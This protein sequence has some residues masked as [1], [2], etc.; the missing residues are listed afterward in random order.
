MIVNVGG[1][2]IGEGHPC[3]VILELG[4]NFK[5]L[6]EA[7]NLVDAG[8]SLG[9]DALKFQTF[10]ARTVAM[11]GA[12]LYDGRGPVDQYEECLESE[13]VETE[14]FQAEIIAYARSK[15]VVAFSTPSHPRDVDLLERIGVPA[16]KFGS[17]DLTNLPLLRYAARLG[18]PIFLSSGVSTLGDV[19]EA[20]R[21]IRKEGSDQ[22]LLFHCV[23][24]YPAKPSEMNLKTMQTLER[25]F[26]VP[27]GLSDH[28]G[29]IA[30]AIAAAALGA[31]MLEKHFTLDRS[32]PGP[33]NFFSMEPGPMKQIIDGIREA[34][35]ALGVPTK[36]IRKS[37]DAMIVN[38]HKSLFAVKDIEP[39]EPVTRDKVDILRPLK[40]IPAKYLDIVL[41]LR[42]ARRIRAGEALQWD[43]FKCGPSI[44]SEGRLAARAEA[45]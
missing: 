6:D 27:V 5:T 11:K 35:E 40:G 39:G 28:T 13:S 2:I 23:S 21:A 43:D 41:G 30:V 33:D 18:K 16:F 26:G 22:I 37:E 9:A 19:D 36:D 4:V 15:G 29:G 20:I 44:P 8:A 34:E 1:R 3:F 45:K 25:A 42:P 10:H 12:I 14:E 38:F 7:K 17:D 31:K 24:Q 32:I